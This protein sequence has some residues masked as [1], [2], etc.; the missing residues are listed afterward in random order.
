[1]IRHRSR[2]SKIHLVLC[3]TTGLSDKLGTGYLSAVAATYHVQAEVMQD[4]PSLSSALLLQAGRGPA[5]GG[6]VMV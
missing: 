2:N 5:S 3:Q 6:H 1:M 4:K